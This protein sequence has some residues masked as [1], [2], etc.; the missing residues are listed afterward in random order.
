MMKESSCSDDICRSR[1]DRILFAAERFSGDGHDK[2]S[3]HS[4]RRMLELGAM[5]LLEAELE[6]TSVCADSMTGGG[7]SAKGGHE[8]QQQSSNERKKLAY[9]SCLEALLEGHYNNL[10]ESG[11]ES[12][13]KATLTHTRTSVL[14]PGHSMYDEQLFLLLCTQAVQRYAASHR[15]L[16]DALASLLPQLLMPGE[17]RL[18]AQYGV[19]ARSWKV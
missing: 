10:R 3:S 8:A 12:R 2:A 6:A 13:V 4:T 11:Q 16:G 9:R 5:S 14:C 18:V 19:H 15:A 7:T 1:Y 17:Q